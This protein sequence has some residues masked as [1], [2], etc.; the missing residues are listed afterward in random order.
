MRSYP[1]EAERRLW[2]ILRGK[3]LAGFKFKRQQPTGPYIVDFINFRHR[4]VIEADG[5][6]H[7]GNEVDALRSA[8]LSAQGFKVVRFWNDDILARTE[9]VADAVW[10]AL[11]PPLPNPSPAGE[12]GPEGTAN[13]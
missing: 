4:L 1:T 11:Q 7:I 6:Q 5:S 13:V 10:A 2:S 8:W 12:E 9:Q 3:R